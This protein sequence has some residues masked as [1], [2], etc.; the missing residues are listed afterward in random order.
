LEGIALEEEKYFSDLTTAIGQKDLRDQ[1]LFKQEEILAG[2]AKATLQDKVQL[3][4]TSQSTSQSLEKR[5][6]E[7]DAALHQC[8]AL[9]ASLTNQVEVR[10]LQIKVL[11]EKITPTETKDGSI[12]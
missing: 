11:R 9:T 1:A 10:D 5:M 2:S 7:S 8:N 12:N 4:S 6:K 3:S